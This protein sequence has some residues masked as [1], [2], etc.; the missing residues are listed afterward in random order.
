MSDKSNLEATNR[1]IATLKKESDKLKTNLERQVEEVTRFNNQLSQENKQLE[2]RNYDL[3]A[4]N[5]LIQAELKNSLKQQND[6][7]KKLKNL[8]VKIK[9]CLF[10]AHSKPFHSPPIQSFWPAGDKANTTQF[11]IN[12]IPV[13]FRRSNIEISTKSLFTMDYQTFEFIC[14]IITP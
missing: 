1:E 12:E 13:Y 4:E 6:L 3:I 7:E 5:K 14:Q 10:S 11:Y 8:Q 2:D 9:L